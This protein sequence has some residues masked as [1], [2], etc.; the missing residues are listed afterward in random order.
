MSRVTVIVTKISAVMNAAAERVNMT[1]MICFG[2]YR[3][4]MDFNSTLTSC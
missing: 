1:T 2:I 3:M 4:C